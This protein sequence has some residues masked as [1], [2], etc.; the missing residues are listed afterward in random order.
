MI[1]IPIKRI[2]LHTQIVARKIAWWI[3]KIVELIP[4]DSFGPRW[5]RDYFHFNG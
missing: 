2:V 5:R 4:K 3:S 1:T